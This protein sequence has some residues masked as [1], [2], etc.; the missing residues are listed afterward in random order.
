MEEIKM[1]NRLQEWRKKR[2]LSQNDLAKVTK[3]SIST[4]KKLESGERDIAKT[5]IGIM[6]IFAKTLGVTL[7]QL[8]QEDKDEDKKKR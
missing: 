5:G 8:V 1:V 7:E 6:M 4:I 3:V 2:G